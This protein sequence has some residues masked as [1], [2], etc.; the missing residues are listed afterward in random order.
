MLLGMQPGYAQAPTISYS[1]PSA[2]KPGTAIAPLVPV[3][4]GVALFGYNNTPI[5]I[6]K[7]LLFPY[8]VAVDALGNVYVSDNFHNSVKKIPVNGGVP[9]VLASGFNQ[10]EGI[11]VDGS[12]NVYVADAGNNAIKK[13]PVGGGAPVILGSGFIKPDG[14]AV[15]SLG[16]V[17]VADY[18]NI[19]IKKIPVGGGPIVK[20]GAGFDGVNAVAVDL[21]GNVYVAD[22]NGQVKK[23]PVEGGPTTVIAIGLYQTGGVAVD[24]F[25]NVYVT[26]PTKGTTE[27]TAAGGRITLDT[28]EGE[29]IA[30][31]AAGNVYVAES[32]SVKE[33]PVG[34]GS[35]IDLSEGFVQP[36]NVAVDAAGNLYVT[37]TGAGEV[38][39]LSIYGGN[40]IPIG[41]GFILPIGITLDAAGNIYVVDLESHSVIK[42]P[43]G[44]GPPTTLSNAFNSPGGIALDASGNIYVADFRIGLFKIPVAGGAPVYVAPIACSAVALDAAGNIYITV[45]SQNALIKIPVG[46]GPQVT[47]GSGFNDP[48]GILVDA[49]GYVYVAD[50][51]NNMVKI[52]PPGGGS[53]ITIGSGFKQPVGLAL[54]RFGNIFEVDASS[55]SI[56]EVKRTGGYF[57]SP[58]LP[59]GL[60]FD[61]NTGIISGTPTAVSQPTNYTVTAYNGSAHTS[62]NVIIKVLAPGKDASLAQLSI[63]HGTLSPVFSP[64]TTNYADTVGM[65]IT[66]VTISSK[67]ADSTAT[68]KVNGTTVAYGAT[69]TAIPLAVGANNIAVM[70]TAHDGITTRTYSIVVNRTGSPNA[71]LAAL[72]V[73]AGTFT[74]GFLSSVTSYT[75]NVGNETTSVKIT[76]TDDHVGS[77]VTVNSLTVPAGKASEPVLL[78]V[79]SNI[80]TVVVTAQD[81]VT[82]KTYT[83]T[84]I[85]APSSDA[86]LGSLRPSQSGLVPSFSPDST[87]YNLS[88]GSYLSSFTLTASIVGPDETIAIDGAPVMPETASTPIALNPGTNTINVVVTAQD[89]VTTKTYIIKV[90]RAYSSNASLSQMH[91]GT[92]SMNQY[93]TPAVSRYTESL[94]YN[95]TS[96]TIAPIAQDALATIKINGTAVASGAISPLIPL[97]EGSNTITTVV[98]A[99]DGATTKTYTLTVTRAY[100]SN[101]ALAQLNPSAGYMTQ[102]FTPTVTSY[103]DNVTYQNTSVRIT[104]IAQDTLA[105]IKI[106]GTLV[107]SGAASQ[108]IP[109]VEG[110]NTITTIVTAPDGVTTKTYT[111]AVIRASSSDANL[112]QMHPNAGYLNQPFSPTISSYVDT[113]NDTNIQV[114]I[115][116]VAQDPLA[117]I[118][119]NGTAVASGTASPI[120]P[121]PVGNTVIS[122]VVTAPDGVTTKTYTLTMTR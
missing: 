97:A 23:I 68:V 61:A 48:E 28:G 4:S 65:E 2:Y 26:N 66:S 24:R 54:D 29:G 53:P 87:A 1:N 76:P 81:G 40:P 121:L 116:P 45:L 39:K 83:L 55:N 120:I 15:D 91:P 41:T 98:T 44:G 17:Y 60:N 109:L 71:N 84:V 57:I 31:D 33:I 14:V 122:T 47:L 95:C 80:I 106:N 69:S 79:G 117:T 72:H 46:G 43:P 75:E 92:G 56:Y 73:S 50:S 9:I 36:E 59:S 63:S 21:S 5:G 10:P 89:R 35:Q 104:P 118:T 58:N 93:F 7:G 30:V 100:S 18:G 6:Y 38:K 108:A 49:S 16:N 115:T 85:R 27:I 67:A 105:T 77:T 12:G 86:D 42:M 103:T 82:Q 78:E 102:Y 3:S 101:A 20:I 22:N 88:V 70:V 64:A 13:I 11:A 111:I 52:I 113:V 94:P 74:P 112:A 114:S 8:G 32:N 34:G 119:V 96:V 99:A 110:S 90:F 19:A 37:D 25:G 51:E 107:A 62:T